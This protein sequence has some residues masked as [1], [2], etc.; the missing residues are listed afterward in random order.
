M[1]FFSLFFL[2]ERLCGLFFSLFLVRA[3]FASPTNNI[4]YISWTLFEHR[5]RSSPPS[6]FVVV[7]QPTS[8][9]EHLKRKRKVA[10]SLS[11]LSHEKVLKAL[12]LKRESA[13]APARALLIDRGPGHSRL[14]PRTVE[15][16][17]GAPKRCC[18]SHDKGVSF[19][20]HTLPS[21]PFIGYTRKRSPRGTERRAAWFLHWEEENL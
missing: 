7:T 12:A 2:F 19:I 17:F 6:L 4:Q 3:L 21:N 16:F 15:S 8:V 9:E 14:L 20:V 1:S 18:S 11:S 5:F 13:R 10:Y